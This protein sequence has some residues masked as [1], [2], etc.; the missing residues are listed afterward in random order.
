VSR[1]LHSRAARAV[2]GM[3]AQSLAWTGT[4]GQVESSAHADGPVLALG[5]SPGAIVDVIVA[6][7]A[8]VHWIQQPPA[9]TRSFEELRLV[10]AARCAHLFG[11]APADWWVTGDWTTRRPFVCA[12]LPRAMTRPVQDAVD[13]HGGSLRWQT[14]WTLWCSARGCSAPDEGGSALRSARQV[15][16]WHCR[17]GHVDTL[18]AFAVTASTAAEEIDTGVVMHMQLEAAGGGPA[19]PGAVHW[20]DTGDAAALESEAHFALALAPLLPGG[21]T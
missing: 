14:A 2:W 20:A 6:N 12:A 18:A 7:T 13:A 16:L 1:W 3:D 4:S 10:A 17:G 15:L 11:G 8:A 19:Q 5:A 9:Q 21:A